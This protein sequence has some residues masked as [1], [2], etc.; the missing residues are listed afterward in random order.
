MYTRFVSNKYKYLGFSRLPGAHYGL[1]HGAEAGHHD[2]RGQ[3]VRLGRILRQD[4]KFRRQNVGHEDQ[5]SYGG[6]YVLG[7]RNGFGIQ[8][9]I[10]VVALREVPSTCFEQLSVYRRNR[11]KQLENET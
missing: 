4:A 11:C 1:E 10:I 8:T 3:H 2:G 5:T 7:K 9:R 6:Y